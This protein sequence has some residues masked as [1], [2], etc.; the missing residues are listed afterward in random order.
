[1]FLSEFYY[2]LGLAG[3]EVVGI[4]EENGLRVHKTH[5]N[6]VLAVSLHR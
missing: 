5:N 3:E 2:Y 1:L 6:V 4:V